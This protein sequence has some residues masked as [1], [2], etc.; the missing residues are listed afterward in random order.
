[1][2]VPAAVYAFF[3]A[4]GPGSVGWG[5]PMA[6]DIAFALGVL[7]LLGDRIPSGLKVFLAAL[8]IADDIGAVMVIALFY[9]ASIAWNWLAVAA[10]LVA[11]LVAFNYLNVQSPVPYFVVGSVIWFAF[12][13]SGV[14]ATIAGVIVAFTIPSRARRGPVEFVDWAR[15]KLDEILQQDVPGAHVLDSDE[16]QICAM[17]IREE[18]K[19]VQ[20][21]LQRL[22]H[23]LHP[24]TTFAVLPLFAL[25]NAGVPLAGES[26][27]DLLSPVSIGVAA[28][29][30]VG[31]QAGIFAFTWAL[32]RSGIATL[33]SGVGWRHVWGA[34]WLGGI[35]FTMSLFVAG[36]AFGDAGLLSEAKLAI[37]ATSVVAGV[38]GYLVLRGARSPL[39]RS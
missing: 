15:D 18:A 33:P 9:T 1:M 28:G 7:A 30:L 2:L 26:V 27:A 32:V 23:G 13:H 4:G 10:V 24:V 17:E 35:G 16:Q 3:N 5:V 21:P 19:Y 22:M 34:A 25:A 12:L 36:L 14:H 29:L 11:V 39:E 20:A 8:A 6:T 37:L 38:G 31:K